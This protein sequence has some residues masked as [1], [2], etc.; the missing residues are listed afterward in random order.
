MDVNLVSFTEKFERNQLKF[1]LSQNTADLFQKTAEQNIH[2]GF[3][4][5]DSDI[6]PRTVGNYLEPLID[7]AAAAAADT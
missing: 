3:S 2:N 4:T 1:I 6:K 5:T 7:P